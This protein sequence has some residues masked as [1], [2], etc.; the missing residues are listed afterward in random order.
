MDILNRYIKAINTHNFEEVRLVLH[1]DATFFFSD[2]SCTTA[3]Q[4]QTYFEHV[5]TVVKE[6]HYA[7][8]DVV[9]LHKGDSSAT[10]NYTYFYEGY[11]NGTYVSGQG[12]A[13]NVFVKEQERW[14]LIHEHLSPLPKNPS[15]Q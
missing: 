7:A 12:R 4:I 1:P 9:W 14:L 15:Q 5:W 2:Q 6:E 11:I 13:T 3:E 10:C 8:Q